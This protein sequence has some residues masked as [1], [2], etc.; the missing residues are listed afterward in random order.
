MSRTEPLNKKTWRKF[1]RA[2][3]K[4]FVQIFHTG[5][6]RYVAHCIDENGIEWEV[7]RKTN[8]IH[9]VKKPTLFELLLQY[10][11]CYKRKFER[12]CKENKGAR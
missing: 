3:S 1:E 4:K 9:C 5:H 10:L 2:A 11:N 6:W 8:E 7:N 12:F